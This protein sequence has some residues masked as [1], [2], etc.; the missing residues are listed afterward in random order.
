MVSFINKLS[1]NIV[2]GCF[3]VFA[4]VYSVANLLFTTTVNRTT[5]NTEF[6]FT[7]IFNILFLIFFILLLYYLIKKEF[8]K[9]NDYKLL[10]F[11]L[12]TCLILGTIWILINDVELK[13]LD[14][15]YNCYHAA[16]NVLNGNYESLS[17]ASYLSVYPNNIGYFTYLLV[18]LKIFGPTGT[19]YS[20]RFINL[21]FV[22]LG[23]LA[24]YGITN[25][26][27]KDQ[28]T[29]YILIYL[30]FLNMQYVFDSFIMYGNCPSYSLA[31]ISIYYLLKYFENDNLKHLVFTIVTIVCSITI[32]NN[33]LIILI[34][35][36]IYL[37]IHFLNN[38]KISIILSIFLMLLGTYLGTSG[39]QKYWGNKVDINY[40]DTKL[41]TIC[42][43]AYGLNYNQDRP[44]SYTSQFENYHAQN[45]YVK[46]YT[47]N[48]A[49][50][51]I[52]G[53]LNDFK[54]KPSLIFRFY[55][56]KFLASF[57]S[58][59]YDCSDYY[60]ELDNN[61]LVKEVTSGNLYIMFTN[62]FDSGSSIIAIGLV[63][64]ILKEYKKIE[65]KQTILMCIVF[66]GFL[67]HA[68]WEVKAIY[69]YQYFMY[70]LPLGAY[71]I[72]KN[73]R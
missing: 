55:S 18:N 24:L 3:L 4:L 6:N 36:I 10:I 7:S 29:N 41:P 20:I 68:F 30:M 62:I 17:Y 52:D 44:G 71:G 22:L 12:I 31:L 49:K 63:L 11:F 53:I 25:L 64:L 42:W 33:S 57:T 65:L 69:L 13:D 23:Y 15:S 73:I 1:K 56:Q 61:A 9:I 38:K 2:K 46:E 21:S 5:Y 37:F 70:L 66:G 58:P 54:N 32:K 60:K 16:L 19:L 35:E 67:F 47:Q 51:F 50:T 28:K 45:G 43:L 8:F 48:E 34:A 40:N 26:I 72:S 59:T 39:L 14:D 27:F